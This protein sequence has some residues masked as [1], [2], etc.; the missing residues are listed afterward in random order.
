MNESVCSQ[1]GFD[2]ML[3]AKDMASRILDRE[4]LEEI[5]AVAL[6]L[7][8]DRPRATGRECLDSLRSIAIKRGFIKEGAQ[9]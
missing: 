5:F 4:N 9:E 1:D 3:S 6:P 7:K 2:L 8:D